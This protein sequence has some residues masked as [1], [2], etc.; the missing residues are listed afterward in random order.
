[1]KWALKQVQGD[2]VVQQVFLLPLQLPLPL[3]LPLPFP[4]P[5]DPPVEPPVDVVVPPVDVVVPPVDV[6]V[7]PVD[8][9]VPPVDVVVPPVVVE[10]PVDVVVPPVVVEPPVEEVVEL[11][12]PVVVSPPVVVEPPVE[13]V[14]PPVVELDVVEVPPL[15][16]EVAAPP[17]ELEGSGESAVIALASRWIAAVT[18]FLSESAAMPRPPITAIMSA[19]SADDAPLVLRR[20]RLTIVLYPCLPRGDRSSG[21]GQ[22]PAGERYSISGL[23]NSY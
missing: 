7:P 11:V 5:E 3:P 18:L 21:A 12:P 16:P 4:F 20:K 14:V 17:E 13:V 22:K 15:P 6:V 23:V 1:M 19:Y 8:V 9:V 10:P 2:E